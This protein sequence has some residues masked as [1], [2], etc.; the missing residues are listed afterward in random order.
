MGTLKTGWDFIIMHNSAIDIIV[1]SW[2][3]DTHV[4]YL[5]LLKVASPSWN[6]PNIDIAQYVIGYGCLN[7]L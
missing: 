6:I 4:L 1:L 7:D 5:T 3:Y 2:S